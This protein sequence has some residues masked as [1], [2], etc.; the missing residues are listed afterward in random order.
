[1]EMNLI[2]EINYI[3]ETAIRAGKKIYEVYE[4]YFDVYYKDDKT[5]LTKADLEA[6]KIIINRLKS[7][8]KDFD[9]ISEEDSYRRE[10]KSDYCFIIDPLDGTKEFVKK[11][12]EFTVNIALTYKT[13]L[14]LGV[15]YAPLLDELYFAIKGE[16]A[17]FEQNELKKKIHVSNRRH[18]LKVLSSRSH[19]NKNFEK[20]VLE[21]G[22][23]IISTMKMGSSLK[24]CRV[25]KGEY[26][27]YYNFSGKTSI[28]DTAAMEI[29]VFEAGGVLLQLDGSR[30][31]YDGKELKNKNGFMILNSLEN[32]LNIDFIKD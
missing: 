30:I 3:K 25:A 20:L 1:M 29:V 27:I 21:N 14:V 22:D 10:L 26:D 7:R 24:G 9:I 17:Y 32:K 5:P 23:K 28:W 13:K 4:N 31:N 11:N 15:V 12:D 19:N 16:G 2:D 18:N 8:Y 6:N